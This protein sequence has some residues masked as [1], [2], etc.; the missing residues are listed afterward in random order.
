MAVVS[1]AGMG[2]REVEEVT[3]VT[4]V[5]SKTSATAGVL[6]DG[7]AGVASEEVGAMDAGVRNGLMMLIT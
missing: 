5:V 3:A 1:G 2:A 6:D 4:P 7:D